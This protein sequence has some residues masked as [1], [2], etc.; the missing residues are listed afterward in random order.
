MKKIKK[1]FAEFGEYLL[2][3]RE[4]FSQAAKLTHFPPKS[5]F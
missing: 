5:S 1:F 4:V 3:M 2:L